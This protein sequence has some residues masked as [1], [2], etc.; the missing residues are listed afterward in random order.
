MRIVAKGRAVSTVNTQRLGKRG[1]QNGMSKA[2]KKRARTGRSQG[3]KG[4]SVTTE[5][6]TARAEHSRKVH[7]AQ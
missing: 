6:V 4:S 2:V 5:G 7:P 1:K 3:S